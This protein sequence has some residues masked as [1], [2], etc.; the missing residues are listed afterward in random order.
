ML[1]HQ[2]TECTVTYEGFYRY[3]AASDSRSD[4]FR[5][6]FNQSAVELFH[7][8]GSE[9]AAPVLAFQ[10]E[11]EGEKAGSPSIDLGDFF[12]GQRADDHIAGLNQVC[13]QVFNPVI[14][15]QLMFV[16][17]LPGSRMAADE[18]MSH[19]GIS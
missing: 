10:T 1:W 16:R 13:I 3:E 15:W 6:V 12:Y 17:P 11:A 4:P 19:V 5:P 7:V 18:P 8:V 9:L 2:G 14:D